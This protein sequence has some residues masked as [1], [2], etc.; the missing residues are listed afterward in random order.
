[1]AFGLAAGALAPVALAGD[2]DPADDQTA[3]ETRD[4]TPPGVRIGV[5]PGGDGRQPGVQWRG[6]LQR[7]TPGAPQIRLRQ[8]T[9]GA[10]V[11]ASTA[12]AGPQTLLGV[13]VRPLTPELNAQL[14]VDPG[15]GLLVTQVAP[16][17]SAASAGIEVHD[18]LLRL[19]DQWLASP[20]QLTALVRRKQQGDQIELHLLRQAK[21]ETLTVELAR[22]EPAAGPARDQIRQRLGDVTVDEARRIAREARQ[23]AD[24]ARERA[25]QLRDR[26]EEMG[27]EAAARGERATDQMRERVRRQ[28]EQQ[29]D[30][31][32]RAQQRGQ[33]GQR[34]DRPETAPQRGP[35]Q[36]RRATPRG[37]RGG[38]PDV[39]GQRPGP[40]EQRAGE[41]PAERP[42]PEDRR[43]GQRDGGNDAEVEASAEVEAEA[44][45]QEERDAGR[46][47]TMLR[48]Q[49]RV[50]PG[51]ADQKSVTMTD[52]SGTYSLNQRDGQKHFKAVDRDGNELFAGPV[53]TDEQRAALDAGLQAKLAEL[54]AMTEGIDIRVRTPDDTDH[55]DDTSLVRPTDCTL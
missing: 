46:S 5:R 29:R 30:E 28:L 55:T 53:D 47:R 31:Q 21:P 37:P 44:G 15:F 17:S 6:Q 18:V 24:Q 50:G 22:V 26:A 19:D 27:R 11:A 34:A 7:A 32:R 42:Q 14:E 48:S 49:I 43:R 51:G 1:M 13:A 45:A 23:R 33:R 4:A 20:D 52:D 38:Q 40:R 41:R 2:E 12:A 25:D 54:S 39:R 8:A 3:T 10:P 36:E 35:E 9:T 16:G